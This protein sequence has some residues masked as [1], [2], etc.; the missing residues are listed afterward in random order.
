MPDENVPVG[1]VPDGG[2]PDGGVPDGGVPEWSTDP[3]LAVELDAD[4]VLA[5]CRDRF[6]L[7]PPPAGASDAIYFVGNSLGPLPKRAREY[8]DAEF[9]HWS[10]H[11]VKAHRSGEQPWVDYHSRLAGPMARIV[12][13][14]LDEVV[15]MNA[16]TVNLHLLMVSFYRPTP[17]RH[18]VLIEEHAFPSDH[19]AVESQIRLHGHDPEDS[20]VL[21]APRPGEE[22]LHP[23][24]IVA[25][26]A[27]HG[28]S[29]ATVLL[30]GVQY[31][32]GQVMPIDRIVEAGHAVG[33]TVGIDLAHAVGNI[34]LS[35]HDCN[36]D[37]ATWCS[38]KYLNSSPGGVSGIFVHDRH[39]DDQ[40]LP[41]LLG[42]WG[43]RLDTRF[44]MVNRFDPP[45]TAES[46]QI[47]N[48][49][50]LPMAVLRASLEIFD[51]AGGMATL[52]AKSMRQSAYLLYLVDE[53]LPGRVESITPREPE[54]RGCQLSL[55]VIAPGVDGER[56][57]ETL[58]AAGVFCDWRYPDVIR[59]APT[60][61]YNSFGDIRR[62]VDILERAISQ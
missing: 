34:E 7:P 44:E 25:A 48:G 13:A 36:V 16:L 20:L 19:F 35:L 21:V 5:H 45:P 60:P 10:E 17:D 23:D 29:L 1:D 42:W 3:E 53:L 2:V 12:G 52:R 31:Y 22:L 14:E 43:T 61:L 33:A 38:Y 18:K 37:F 39:I 9:D 54:Q 46:W 50:V 57:F 56:V 27:E 15:V 41:K 30:P 59:V 28:D 47:S 55:R 24:D 26:I 40:T 8:V 6:E 58:E 4:D 32:T 62:F 51:E 11:G 49:A